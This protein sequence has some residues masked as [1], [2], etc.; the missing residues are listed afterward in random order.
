MNILIEVLHILYTQ[1]YTYILSVMCAYIHTY[2]H[3]Q[4]YVYTYHTHTLTFPYLH[5]FKFFNFK[6][7]ATI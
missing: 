6:E 3:M 2:A 1:I 4:T 5:T 7:N